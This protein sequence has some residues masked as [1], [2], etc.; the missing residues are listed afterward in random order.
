MFERLFENPKDFPK[1]KSTAMIPAMAGP[2]TYQGHGLLN[3]DIIFAFL[4]LLVN[5]E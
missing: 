3:N 2:E 4:D 5:Y 1:N